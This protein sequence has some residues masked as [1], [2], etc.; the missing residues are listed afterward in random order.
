MIAMIHPKFHSKWAEDNHDVQVH[1]INNNYTYQ[2][3]VV[4]MGRVEGCQKKYTSFN[5]INQ[6]YHAFSAATS[7]GKQ[8]ESTMLTREQFNMHHI[9]FKLS[10]RQICFHEEQHAV[11]VDAMQRWQEGHRDRVEAGESDDSREYDEDC[12][13][14]W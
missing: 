5:A 11:R 2:Q 12:E 7:P 3:A 1:I 6:I 4:T 10:F 14:I 8:V 9:P 13:L